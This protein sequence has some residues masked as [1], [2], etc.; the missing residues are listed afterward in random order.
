MLIYDG[1]CG[2]CTSTAAWTQRVMNAPGGVRNGEV[3][4]APW[5]SLDL[6]SLGLTESEVSTAAYWAAPD[7]SLYRGHLGVAK[8]LEHA[9]FPWSIIGKAIETPPV[10]WLA[11]PVYAVIAKNRHR[12]PGSTDACH[13]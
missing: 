3:V 5:Q 10:S 6:A 12:L 4:V 11:A 2:F 7:G 13:L 9:G 1:D 8:A